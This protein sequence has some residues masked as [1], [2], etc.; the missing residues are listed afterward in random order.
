[1]WR[2]CLLAARLRRR[3]ERLTGFATGVTSSLERGSEHYAVNATR[4]RTLSSQS[5]L[6]MRAS[7][8]ES[9]VE[10]TGFL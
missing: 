7:L 1:L 9:P 4:K 6:R 10:I 3:K 8:D 5:G 2:V